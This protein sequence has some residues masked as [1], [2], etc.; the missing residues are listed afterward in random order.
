M[1]KG[2]NKVDAVI[3]GIEDIVCGITL[4]AIVCI[5][6]ASVFARYI[7]HSGFLWADEVNQALLVAMGMFGSARAVRTDGHTEFSMLINLPKTKGMRIAL[8]S[9][10]FTI[11][12]VFLIFMLIWSAQYTAGG[13]MLSTTLR[14]PRMYYYLS[15]PLGFAL[16]V[17]EYL[18][19][20]KRRTIDDP[21]PLEEEGGE[22][23]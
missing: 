7:F 18:R 11:T 21:V 15:I 4:A 8:R 16:M 10:F 3:H 1:E 5:A 2:F 19:S 13:T 12:V 9:I 20:V 14:V 22:L 6:T 23:Q 17:Y